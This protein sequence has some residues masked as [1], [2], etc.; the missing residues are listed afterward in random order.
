MKNFYIFLA[1]SCFLAVSGYSQQQVMFTQY[2][3]N[4][5][6][7]NP[8]VV[9]SH[10]TMSL[11]ALARKQW[12]GIEGA[13]ETQTLS[14]HAPLKKDKIALGLLFLRDEI[15]VSS[16]NAVFGA[17]AYRVAFNNGATL[18]MGLQ[19]GFADYRS[20]FLALDPNNTNTNDNSLVTNTDRYF[21]PNFGAGLYYYTDRF[22]AGVSAPLL[23]NSFL[24]GRLGDVDPENER[25]DL[26]RHYFGM[27]GF[28]VTL[29]PYLKLKPSALLKVVE[30]APVEMDFNANLIINEVFWLGASYR[31]F[32]SFSALLEIQLSE[33][34]RFG[35]AY[36]LIVSDLS[37]LTSG[38]HEIML[39][40]RFSF[41]KDR[42]ITPRYF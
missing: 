11:T 38:S 36:D 30:G 37:P 20:D 31:S 42:L 24:E 21:L 40:Y 2:M 27:A 41:H 5:T 17:Y 15:G 16:Q 9:G 8:A 39:N 13:P 26:K 32:D 35:Y 18:S 29:S 14:L 22:Y 12:V 6:A 25:I 28:I 23:L 3:F 10:E 4:A 7:I 33:K 19:F 34:F 1:F